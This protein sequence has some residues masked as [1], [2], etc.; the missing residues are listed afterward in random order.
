M[1]QDESRRAQE[2]IQKITD[3]S[4]AEM[5]ELGSAKEAAVMEV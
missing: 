3:S 1:S 5:E 4:I 2:R